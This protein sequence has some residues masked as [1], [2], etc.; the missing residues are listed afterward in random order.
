ML[1]LDPWGESMVC[2]A[3]RPTPQP[4][5]ETQPAQLFDVLL[6]AH[7]VGEPIEATVVAAALA[8]RNGVCR[9]G[10]PMQ[11]EH[12]ERA[13]ARD[14]AAE[15][16]FK[17]PDP[18]YRGLEVLELA[19]VATRHRDGW[20]IDADRHA[21]R[22]A[23]NQKWIEL[24]RDARRRGLRAPVLFVVGL[25]AGQKDRR[26][27]QT[28][29]GRPRM[30]QITGWSL[31]RIDRMTRAAVDRGGL[32]R[33]NLPGTGL[34]CYAQGEST[35]EGRPY[36]ESTNEGRDQANGES[37]NP[38]WQ[39]DEPRVAN[40]RTPCGESTNADQDHQEN[41][42]QTRTPVGTGDGSG[43]GAQEQE[44]AAREEADELKTIGNWISQVAGFLQ[45]MKVERAVGRSEDL[46]AIVVTHRGGRGVEW[47]RDQLEELEKDASIRNPRAALK[48]RIHNGAADPANDP[49]PRPQDHDAGQAIAAENTARHQEQAEADP[50]YQRARIVA[51]VNGDRKTPEEAAE[52]LGVPL[53]TVHQALYADRPQPRPSKPARDYS[54][55][56][57]GVLQR[58]AAQKGMLEAATA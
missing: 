49:P 21:D 9:D 23:D 27:Q 39:S 12:G 34:P 18:V 48:W 31:S 43:G 30:Q 38:V 32:R 2:R 46:A 14:L 25:V 51:I 17:N 4:D 26:N 33:W 8:A 28:V 52:L 1:G 37:T 20:M 53:A 58:L 29:M 6:G 11:G 54:T 45:C 44:Q 35:N 10:R 19:G 47:V 40:R 41:Q 42:D 57:D 7:V 36:G 24:D 3:P 56:I 22:C 13:T 55:G 5:V 50:A 15:L 16:G